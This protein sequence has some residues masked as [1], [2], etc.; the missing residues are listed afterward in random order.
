MTAVIASGA[1]GHWGVDVARPDDAAALQRLFA[2]CSPETV[3]N[4]F[5]A[6]VRAWPHRYLAAVLAGDPRTH[7]AV[8][9]RY[10]DG[11]HLAGLASLAAGSPAA[12]LGVLVA[13]AFQHQ[14]LGAAMVEALLGRARERGVARVA[15]S[16]LP[17]RSA[18][19]L[20]LARRLPLEQLETGGDGPTG[21]Y[22]LTAQRYEG[23]VGWPSQRAV[24]GSGS[25]SVPLS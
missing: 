20:A 2:D 5:F 6:R 15:A 13:D 10:G 25:S 18:L 12:E 14:G 17:G 11:L 3:H 8:V 19:L 9:V 1:I 22:R 23:G 4:R 16:V 24:R 7:D 21:I